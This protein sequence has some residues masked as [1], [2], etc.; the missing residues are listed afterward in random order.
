M[1]GDDSLIPRIHSLCS[2]V[3]VYLTSFIYPPLI[4]FRIILLYLLCTMFNFYE[5]SKAIPR[6]IPQ[7][8]KHCV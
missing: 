2:A 3:Q 8:A 1:S 6:Y 5:I 4:M 7:P